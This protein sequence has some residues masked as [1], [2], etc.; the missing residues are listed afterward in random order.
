MAAR[1]REL[2]YLNP[3]VSIILRDER[4]AAPK[5]RVFEG[6][7]GLGAF[8]SFLTEG[9]NRIGDLEDKLQASEAALQDYAAAHSI[10]FVEER[11]DITTEKLAQF[12]KVSPRRGPS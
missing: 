8:V 3:G 2:S 10:L 4:E 12:S 9:K 1:F 7:G 5:E 11:K 6:E